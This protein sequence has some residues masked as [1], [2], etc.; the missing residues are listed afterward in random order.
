MN[1]QPEI[2]P[3][4]L[5][6]EHNQR[7]QRLEAQIKNINANIAEIV[8]AINIQRELQEV[9]Q[10]TIDKTL[11]NQQQTAA[12]IAQILSSSVPLASGQH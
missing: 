12:L 9:N 5:M 7:I 4:E 2:D 10:R 11:E 3:W 6:I 8:K 1:I